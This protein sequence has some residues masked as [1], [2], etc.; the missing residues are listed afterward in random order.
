MN[1]KSLIQWRDDSSQ[2]SL[3]R[4]SQWASLGLYF[5]ICKVGLS[6]ISQRWLRR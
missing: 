2:L 5:P 3:H 6:L 4:P 1:Q